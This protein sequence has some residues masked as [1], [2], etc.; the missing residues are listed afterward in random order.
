MIR[1]P[2]APTALLLLFA[3]SACG[4][5]DVGSPTV[6]SSTRSGGEA[7]PP[8]TVPPAAGQPPASVTASIALVGVSPDP[9]NT[10]IVAPCSRGGAT[11]ECAAAWSGTFEVTVTAAVQYPVLTVR[12][13][14]ESTLCGYA[15][16]SWDTMLPAGA[17]VFQPKTIY[18]T[19]EFG[20]FS[21]P[22]ALPARATRMVAELWSD[23]D[24]S[25]SSMKQEFPI[26]YTFVTQ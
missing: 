19:D 7:P 21:P 16:Q 6:P 14:N 5:S 11:R 15:A 23:A 20:T 4:G 25:L 17:T 3:L 12:F 24:G 2:Y 8:P 18:L 26:S 9:G 10:L 13:Y 1:A 22:C